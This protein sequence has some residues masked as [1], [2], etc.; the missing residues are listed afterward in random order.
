MRDI[1]FRAWDVT[2]NRPDYS[3]REIEVAEAIQMLG[4]GAKPA[5]VL[6][7]VYMGGMQEGIEIAERLLVREK[8]RRAGR[9]EG[10]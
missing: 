10:V 9:Q 7:I 4:S 8:K 3:R 5:T 1:K 2:S 6:K